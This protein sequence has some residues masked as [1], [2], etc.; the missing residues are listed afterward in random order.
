[1]IFRNGF[2][3][4]H[5]RSQFFGLFERNHRDPGLGDLGME[6]SVPSW[7]GHCQSLECAE[8]GIA[9]M[10][11]FQEPFSTRDCASGPDR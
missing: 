8:L 6:R 7:G 5:A 4:H 11:F 2:M 1:M 10:R 3:A 9:R